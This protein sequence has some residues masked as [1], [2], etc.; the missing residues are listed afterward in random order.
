MQQGL[1]S[2]LDLVGSD[3]AHASGETQQFQPA[4]PVE[5]SQPVG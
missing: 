5:E 2:R 4:G 3:A 1:S